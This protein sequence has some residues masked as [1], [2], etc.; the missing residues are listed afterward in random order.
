MTSGFSPIQQAQLAFSVCKQP[1]AL[2]VFRAQ[3]AYLQT[4]K[5]QQVYPSTLRGSYFAYN[6]CHSREVGRG[7]LPVLLHS[8]TSISVFQLQ[9][10]HQ[11]CRSKEIIKE[12][13]S[14]SPRVQTK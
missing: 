3:E 12:K 6:E 7:V 5:R 8:T 13:M 2:H 9:V 10:L 1:A 4:V 14:G 11:I